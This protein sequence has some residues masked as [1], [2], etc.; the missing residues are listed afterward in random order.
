MVVTDWRCLLQ[1]QRCVRLRG[2]HSARTPA[3]RSRPAGAAHT[4]PSPWRRDLAAQLLPASRLKGRTS[5]SWGEGG[6]RLRGGAAPLRH[7]ITCSSR[8]VRLRAGSLAPPPQPGVVRGAEKRSSCRPA[9]RKHGGY[10]R[11]RALP[12]PARRLRAAEGPA[13]PLPAALSRSLPAGGHG[14]LVAFPFPSA[15]PVSS[16]PPALCFAALVGL[17]FS[18]AIGLTFLML[19]CALEYYG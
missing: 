14:G 7:P 4:A 13:E 17:S 6:S 18:G 2:T 12:S 16:S 1:L 19:G 11:Y 9:R 5:P 3:S 8:G 15:G 10:Q